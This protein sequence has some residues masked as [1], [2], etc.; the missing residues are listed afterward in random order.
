MFS[1]TEGTGAGSIQKN[2]LDQLNRRSIGVGS[3]RQ[4]KN[5][6]C[7]NFAIVAVSES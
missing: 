2:K 7:S 5:S 1:V 3:G 6:T 4:P